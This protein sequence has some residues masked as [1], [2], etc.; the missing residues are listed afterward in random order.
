MVE[1]AEGRLR[2]EQNGLSFGIW[3][4]DDASNRA[5]FAGVSHNGNKD[6]EAVEKMVGK[7]GA[8]DG[9][10]SV[11]G[12]SAPNLVELLI[13]VGSRLWVDDETSFIVAGQKNVMEVV[14]GN[15]ATIVTG[16]GNDFDVLCRITVIGCEELRFGFLDFWFDAGFLL[17]VCH[18][19]NSIPS[20]HK[21]CYNGCYRTPLGEVDDLLIFDGGQ[22]FTLSEY[23]PHMCP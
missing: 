6:R 21:M 12:T 10:N 9:N 20:F 2:V 8:I 13:E 5:W 22:V 19:E 18:D 17:R 16:D 1:D 14:C 15:I 23:Y 3:N 4:S 11:I 7:T